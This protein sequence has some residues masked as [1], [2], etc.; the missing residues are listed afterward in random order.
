MAN[1]PITV[2]ALSEYI[3]DMLDSD[4]LLQKVY[5][6][7]ELSNFKVHSSGHCYFSLKDEGAVINAVM[8]R[9]DAA[10]LRFRPESGMKVI[11]YGRVS[12]FPKSGQYQ[13][14]VS[15]MQPDGVGSLYVA[16]EQLKEKLYKEGLFDKKY[17]KPLPRYPQKIG[18]VT[19]PTG[20]A[21]RDMIRIIGSRYKAAE[22]IVCP[23]LVQGDTAAESIANMIKYVNEHQLCDVIICGRGGG[24]IEDLWC[25]NDEKVARAVFE[26]RIPVISAVGHEPDI[27]IIDYV[28]DVRASTPSNGAEIVVPDSGEML[29]RLNDVKQKLYMMEHK[30]IG[31]LKEKLAMLENNKLM[32]SPM[33][34]FA[35]KNMMLGMQEQKLVNAAEKLM[36]S[37][38][39]EYVRLVSMLDALSPLKVISRGYG[40]VESDGR[41][42]KSI[43]DIKTDSVI[44]TSLSDGWFESVVTK[45]EEKK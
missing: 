32:R 16:F 3:K 42:V 28:A 31:F 25:F 6:V 27:T 5:V 30:K 20:A 41:I 45:I 40:M 33:S 36:Q 7:G 44:K 43:D 39:N 37:K 14:Y 21:V 1:K 2:T 18:L 13:I 4:V 34:Y 12:L 24:S 15:N 38:K 26:S 10:K 17:K 11:L 8:F 23:V 35:D 22:I 9:G 29:M 19:S